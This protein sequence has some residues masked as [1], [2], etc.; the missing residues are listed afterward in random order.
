MP[1]LS[2][3]TAL[4]DARVFWAAL[5][6]GC[7]L[8]LCWVCL[9]RAGRQTV[10]QPAMATEW[11]IAYASQSGAAQAIAEQL[12]PAFH[13]QNLQPALLPLNALQPGALSGYSR[14]LFRGPRRIRRKTYAKETLKK[15]S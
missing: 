3:L 14:A 12:L 6:C 7:W 9:V 8:A 10:V 4:L 5:A 11:L 13:Q 1:E 2:S 15:T